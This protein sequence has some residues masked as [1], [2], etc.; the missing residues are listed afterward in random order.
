MTGAEPIL[1]WMD[2]LK[3]TMLSSNSVL[4]QGPARF[5][6]LDAGGEPAL[7]RRHLERIRAVQPAPPLP[8]CFA[9]T[10]AHIDHIAGLT[11]FGELP[12]AWSYELAAHVRGLRTMRA[13]DREF[14]LADLTGRVLSAFHPA[15]WR[16]WTVQPKDAGA[17]V[18]DL[19]IPLG[20]GVALEAY[21]TPGHSPDSVC[22]RANRVLF[23]G[24]LLAATAPLVAGIA[25]W[26]RAALL[27]SLDRLERIL[28]VHDILWVHVGHGRPLDRAAVAAALARSRREAEELV[29]VAPVDVPRLR[30]TAAYA[31]GLV[32]ELEDLFGEIALRISRLADKLS[33]I[34]ESRTADEVREIDRSREV[35]DL[36]EAFA[37]FKTAAEARGEDVLGVAAKGVRTALRISELLEWDRLDRV[38]DESL[39]RYARTRVVDFI[40]RAKGLS[41]ALD[42]SG[43]DLAE[44]VRAFVK[45]LEDQQI[46]ACRL[47]DVS[48]GEEGFRRQ[49]VHCLSRTP[50]LG[51]AAISLSVQPG[52]VPARMDPDRFFDALTRLIECRV[53]RG[54]AQFSL[55]AARGGSGS[56]LTL[57]AE[58]AAWNF[59]EARASVWEKVFARSGAKVAIPASE[60]RAPLVFEFQT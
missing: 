5:V 36:L 17:A 14:S 18:P 58:G 39:L 59:A 11:E 25:G 24:D 44:G 50:S 20:G 40:Q 22:W 33:Q 6:V 47:D 21:A 29:R 8:V 7:L 45:R 3:P 48:G 43:T 54:T 12:S 46:G 2:S 34:Q 51:T 60:S 56:V 52:P 13:A 55:H 41:P 4:L 53:A 26:D 15:G 23:A 19:A 35:G 31:N 9:Q 32:D 1:L 37:Q 38:L 27:A 16:E 42:A 49:L 57:G 30:R 28:E 10:H